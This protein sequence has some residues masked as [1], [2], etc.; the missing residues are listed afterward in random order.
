MRTYEFRNSNRFLRNEFERSGVWGF[1]LIRKQ[2]IDLN[3]IELIEGEM[4][5]RQLKML[6]G[7][8]ALHQDELM[9]NWMLAEGKQELF[10]IDPL[11]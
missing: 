11:K 4:P 10:A 5:N 6:L 2:E 1:P 7:W 9:E 3:D 8:A